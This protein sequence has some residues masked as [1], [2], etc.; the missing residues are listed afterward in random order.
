[1]MDMTRGKMSRFPSS[2]S[3]LTANH[4]SDTQAILQQLV[5]LSRIPYILIVLNKAWFH[6]WAVNGQSE[7]LTLEQSQEKTVMLTNSQTAQ[8][9]VPNSK[10]VTNKVLQ[11]NSQS[12]VDIC[13]R[14]ESQAVFNVLCS[15][16]C[17][18]K[19]CYW[20]LKVKKLS[21]YLLPASQLR[22]KHSRL[23]NKSQT[24]AGKHQL[25]A[26]IQTHAVISLTAFVKLQCRRGEVTW[27]ERETE[28]MDH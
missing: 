14:R 4:V 27:N 12:N 5:S 6:H 26:H 8:Y 1:M 23:I 2:L 24:H 18:K 13:S 11:V 17:L 25:H 19:S 7:R 9:T 28:E 21:E 22:W 16:K 10:G 3:T 15:E 20:R